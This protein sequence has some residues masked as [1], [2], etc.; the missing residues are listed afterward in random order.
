MLIIRNYFPG[1]IIFA[2]CIL[3]SLYSYKDHGIGWDE[4]IQRE[5]GTVSYNY[6]V[7][8]DHTLDTYSNREY[9]TGFEIPLVALEKVFGLQD[10]RDIYL[11]RHLVSHLFFLLACFSGY[12]LCYRLF[13]NNVIACMGFLLFVFHP[14]IFAHSYI[15]SKDIPFL[16]MFLVSLTLCQIAFD[17]NKTYWY[18]LLGIACGYTTSIRLPGIILVCIISFFLFVD[19]IHAYYKKQNIRQPLLCF[20]I[21]IAATGLVLYGAFPTLWTSPIRSFADAYNSMSHYRWESTVLLN[22]ENIPGTALPWYYLPIWFC[23]TTPVLWLIAGFVAI[24]FIIIVFIRRPMKFLLNTRER[25]FI[26]YLACFILPMAAII[27][28]KS[29]VYDDWRHVYF[30]YPPFVLLLLYAVEKAYRSRGKKILLT[31]FALQFISVGYFMVRNH[32]NQQV[33]FNE[34]VSHK[35]EFLRYNYDMDYWGA[36]FKQGLDY[37]VHARPEGPIRV[38][39]EALT[40]SCPLS[41][42][43]RQLPPRQRQRMAAVPARYADYFITNFRGHPENYPYPLVHHICVCGDTILAVYQAPAEHLDMVSR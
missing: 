10:T 21:F 35:P 34:L 42:N 41:L 18:L 38:S 33:Y 13:R 12:I 23:I 30:I 11:M 5:I 36:S 8:D 37:I 25:N 19:I 17:K 32:P 15:N 22:G 16:S 2:L 27:V 20:I 14:R 29:V 6:I 9:G 3:L 4:S 24:F 7:K 39:S 28:L 40:G 43:I 26:I 1:I 31:A